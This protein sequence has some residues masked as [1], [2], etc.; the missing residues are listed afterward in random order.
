MK[1]LLLFALC[2]LTSTVFYAHEPEDGYAIVE[3]D[4]IYGKYGK[5]KINFDSGSVIVKQDTINR[6]FLHG[7]KSITIDNRSR[8]TYLVSEVNNKNQFYKIVVEGSSP[9]MEKDGVLY[10]L[11]DG[12]P[13]EVHDKNLY[14]LFGKKSVKTISFLR[15]ISLQKEDDIIDLFNYY[16]GL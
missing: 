3:N 9:L 2:I 5:V 4:T 12:I 10:C 16:N 13:T 6:M 7:I 11:M 8:D 14:S 1:C 15:N